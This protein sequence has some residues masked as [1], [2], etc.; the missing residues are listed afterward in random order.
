MI[1]D[2]GAAR[3]AA[4]GDA[5]T[6]RLPTAAPFHLEA[7]VRVLQRRPST[8]EVWDGQRYWRVFAA[9]EGLVLAAVDNRGSVDVPDLRLAFPAGAP[10]AGVRC[11]VE[12]TVRRMLGLDV[13]PAPL[14]AAVLRVKALRPAAMALRGLRPPR[15]A[16]LFDTF[17]SVV[18][19]Q[20]LSLDAGAAIVGRL[21]ERFGRQMSYDNRLFAV[22]PTASAIANARRSALIA[23]G[24]SR[25]KA[26][27]LRSLAKLVESG[28]LREEELEQLGTPAALARLME[29]PG[30]GPWSAA[31]V[32]LRGFGRLE[33]FP[34]GDSGAQ[35]GLNSLLRLR[36]PDSLERVVRRFGACRGYLYFCSLGASLLA[37][38]LIRPAPVPQRR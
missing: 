27:S 34:P 35:R 37:R 7:T 5:E 8:H 28:E 17:A 24:L 19:F 22:F 11:R 29:L 23:C 1:A 14:E 25:T 12:Q 15:V 33:V 20:Q 3:A 31:V 32:L 6:I 9:A 2:R 13:D 36:A 21:I 26:E 18:P 4:R 10:S 30:I 16:T 38:G